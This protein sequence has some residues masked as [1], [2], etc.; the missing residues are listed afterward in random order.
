MTTAYHPQ[1]WLRELKEGLKARLAS[2]ALPSHL[3]L[4]L[5]GMRTMPKDVRALSSTELVYAH[6]WSSLASSWMLPSR[7]PPNFWST[8]S[9]ARVS[10]LLGP[11]G[12]L[13]RR[14]TGSFSR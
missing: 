1:A 7:W 12:S 3:P 4:V 11:S 5:L 6:P 9:Q 14:P 10:S 2:H 8:C 13:S